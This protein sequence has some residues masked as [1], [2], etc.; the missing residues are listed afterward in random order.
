MD[1]ASP[2]ASSPSDWLVGNGELVT[3][4]RQYDWAGT[5]LGPMEEWPES[6]RTAVGM[7]LSSRAQICLFWGPDRVVLYNDAYTP[8]LG[9]KHPWALGRPGREVWSEIWEAQLGPLLQGVADTGESFWASAL[10]F[11]LQRHGFL[12][13]TYFDI[14]Y[15]PV[16]DKAGSVAGMYCIVT[17]MSGR[18]VGERRLRALGGLG[19][20]GLDARSVAE[21]LESAAGELARD[22]EDVPFALLY[23][24]DDEKGVARLR[25]RTGIP[26]E[27]P[28]AVAEITP[29]PGAPWPIHVALAK[30]GVVIDAASAP[31]GAFP[32]GCWPE[33]CARVA[34]LPVAM[35]SQAPG[36]FLVA[37]LSPRRPADDAYRE[38]LML[39]ATSIGSALASVKALETERRRGHALAE[40]DRA[41]TIFFS[42]ISH[43]F[44]TPLTL[45]LGPLR[46]QL[47]RGDDLPAETRRV[48]DLSYRNGLRLLKLVN[49]LLDFSRIEAGRMSA[50]FE[51][52]DLA[53]CTAELASNF[54]SAFARAGLALHIDCP[55]LAEPAYV[56]RDMWE[57][58]V[59]NLL[60]NAFKYTFEGGVY[61]SLSARDRRA[62]LVV[63]D[64]GVGIPP[65]A[66]PRI[67]ERFHRIEGTR[68]RTH[69]GSGIGLALVSELVRM[70]GGEIRAQ[71][72][73][74]EGTV[75]EVEIPLGCEHLPAEQLHAPAA[76]GQSGQAP[77]FTQEL[78]GWLREPE[79]AVPAALAGRGRERIL[80]AEDSA[81]M[82]EYIERLL[83]EW[84]EVVTVP[85]GE[86]AMHALFTARFDLLLTDVMM[87]KIDG[88]A[89]LKAVRSDEAVRDLPVIMLSARAGEEARIEGR[90]AGADDYL[91]KPFSAREL[92]AQVRAQLSLARVRRA[93][94]R[95]R[96]MLL[97]N[98][99]AAR[100]D[101]ERQ[102]EDLIRLFE[103][104]PNPMVILRG[105]QNVIE[106]ANPA[107]CNVWG[108]TLE[109]V[110][111]KPLFEALPEASGQGLEELLADVLDNGVPVGGQ[112]AI[113][114]DRG[115]GMETVH[116]DFL[117]SPLR[118]TSGRVEGIAV[119][120]F[121]IT[122]QVVARRK[123]AEAEAA[124]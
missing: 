6:L 13:E 95:E 33:P 83:G 5:S 17:E 53:R 38:F 119:T 12:E 18:V 100:M 107:A 97:A 121:D 45:L 24:W 48:L 1:T 9:G 108:R 56:D 67:F 20:V 68:A 111:H 78:M 31:G 15:D 118:A 16:R 27:H 87:P 29:G 30:E 57:K 19:R 110:M 117:Y 40:L 43:E 14:S 81:D 52:T 103:Q 123:L 22:P 25:G 60:S 99:R 11:C 116:F 112:V 102:W 34:V 21:V 105:R 93:T 86:A 2:S 8:V 44:R 7:L 82:R 46:D 115:S 26:A 114:L 91:V 77:M 85:D 92:V 106:L 47:S 51:P 36:A 89:L 10:L 70:H 63:R 79:P 65:S 66:I 41:K 37:G 28:A 55:P 88:F 59:L 54:E 64:T 61:V 49:S 84:W 101:A 4:I 74:G 80:V 71:S 42:N 104:A 113:D 73:E 98:E 76:P 58:V 35:P 94:A 69:E 39:V 62:I 32:G 122:K 23:E 72:R 90:D 3:R 109:Q 124:A 120:A 96:E 50:R 75:F